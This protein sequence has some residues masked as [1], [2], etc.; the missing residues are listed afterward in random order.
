MSQKV[1]NEEAAQQYYMQ[2]QQL[3]QHIKQTQHQL[4][5]IEQ[6][7]MEA[8]VAKNGIDELQKA[9]VGS[10]MLV[11]ITSGIF[12]KASLLN[13][14]EVLMNVGGKTVVSK[15]FK[16]AKM[17]LEGQIEEMQKAQEKLGNQ[18]QQ[19]IMQ[20]KA[21]EQEMQKVMN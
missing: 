18:L 14:S 12:V 11:P 1:A 8:V 9:K 19:L 10:E 2:F 3:Q 6:H 15:D 7:M 4:E 16:K 13:N 20:A 5:G 21:I 17:L